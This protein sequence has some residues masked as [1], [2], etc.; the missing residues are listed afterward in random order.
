[1]ETNQTKPSPRTVRR[2]VAKRVQVHMSELNSNA[3]NKC[4]LS[5]NKTSNSSELETSDNSSVSN[6][7]GCSSSNIESD[8][9]NETDYINSFPLS[10]SSENSG[11]TLEPSVVEFKSDLLNWV[12]KY[13]IP[14]TAV[15][16]LLKLLREFKPLESLPSDGR[17]LLKNSSS[18][19]VRDLGDGKFCYF[20]LENTLSR[21]LEQ[22]SDK[23]L[24]T[25]G[26]L[27]IELSV[28]GLPVSK[29][30]NSQ[31]WP[32]QCS[33]INLGIEVKPTV[34]AIYYGKTKP[35]DVDNYFKDFINEYLALTN[36]GITFKNRQF[37][38]RLLRIIADAPARSFLKQCKL[39][40][41]YSGCEKCTYPG[42]HKGRVIFD[43]LNWPLRNDEDFRSQKDKRHHIGVSPLT[44]IRFNLVTGV[45]LDYMHLICL[46]VVKKFMKAWFK[47]AKGNCYKLSLN[48]ISA[49]STLLV[50][51]AATCPKEFNRK[52]RSLRELDLWK[53]TEFRS[54]LL[55]TGPVVLK[56][57]LDTK[58][59]KHFMLLSV[60]I[61]LLISPCAVD[62]DWNSFAKLLL[63]QFTESV[64]TLYEPEFMV[65]NVHNLIHLADDAMQN[66]PLDKFS[67]FKYENN[68]QLIKRTLRAKYK[69][70]EQ[71]INR[72]SELD[73]IIYSKPSNINESVLKSTSGN[74]CYLL[75]SGKTIIITN[76]DGNN[77]YYRHFKTQRN[78]F[79]KPCS[80]DK[81]RIFL[82]SN[83]SSVSVIDKSEISYKCWLL[84]Y[85][86]KFVCFPL[87]N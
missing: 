58:K 3:S 41:A 75:S 6:S 65:Y 68:M 28:D 57:V 42:K 5:V 77:V 47:P 35:P 63:R 60:A 25:S 64:P 69:P 66:G 48:N 49:I 67:A 51:S 82:V 55:Y 44:K 85:K 59:Y 86:D 16:D 31:L 37:F 19:E 20:G 32:I 9:L 40:N 21:Q 8:D 50:Q 61:R 10:S 43:E 71:V 72:I 24:P 33:L 7:D 39:H 38:I 17:T 18:T 23:C 11:A 2:Q 80:S 27:Q 81:L 79:E 26:E 14:R 15:T 56:H 62:K 78:F 76:T 74:N 73:F 36:T 46:G 4:S 12:L 70:F 34:I 87:V 84:P 54:F 52:P 30:T 83:L 29:S 13:N 53:A 1:M 22:T 45:P